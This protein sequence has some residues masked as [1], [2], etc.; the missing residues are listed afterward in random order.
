MAIIAVFAHMGDDCF[1][2]HAVRTRH[3]LEANV[4]VNVNLMSGSYRGDVVENEVSPLVYSANL[5]QNRPDRFDCPGQ[6][7]GDRS[8]KKKSGCTSSSTTL[9]TKSSSFYLAGVQRWRE[10]VKKAL[11]LLVYPICKKLNIPVNTMLEGQQMMEQVVEMKGG[12]ERNP[13]TT[14]IDKFDMRMTN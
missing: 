9:S 6:T 14:T 8:V 13:N 2:H 5:M 1:L 4:I 7:A 10:W 11:P 12:G 3:E